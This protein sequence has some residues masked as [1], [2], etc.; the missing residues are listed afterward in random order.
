MS[1]LMGDQSSKSQDYCK[2]GPKARQRNKT[3][4]INRWAFL[5]LIYKFD[6]SKKN[7]KLKQSKKS[8]EGHKR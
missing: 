2:G 6:Q 3:A 8:G 5:K 7:R 1:I 4:K